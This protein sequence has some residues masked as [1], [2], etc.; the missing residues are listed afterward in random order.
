MTVTNRLPPVHPGEILREEMDERDL[1]ANALAE[2]LNIPTNRITAILNGQ[3][4]VTAETAH[5]LSLHFGTTS[6][7]WLN[8]QKTWELRCAEIEAEEG[9]RVKFIPSSGSLV[10]G[11]HKDKKERITEVL[12]DLHL[13]IGGFGTKSGQYERHDLPQTLGALAR[14]CSVFLRKLVLGDRGDRNTRLLDDAIMESLD[15]HLQPLRK[16]PQKQRRTIRTGFG[17]GNGFMV[18][19]KVDEPGP[20]LAP[21]YRLPIAPHDLEFSIEWPLPGTVDWIGIPSPKESW[22]ICAEQ[23]FDTGSARKLNC[24]NWL[25][26]QVVLFDSK[27]I[28]LK[29]IIRTVVTYEGVHAINVARLSEVD[30]QKSFRPAKEPDLHLLNNITLFGIRFPHLIVIETALYLYDR[31]LDEPSIQRPGGDIYLVK[32][33]FTCREDQAN[34]PRPD[35]LRFEG[36]IM[37]TFAAEPGL[38]RHTIRPVA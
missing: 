28:S 22:V 27:G 33:G 6:E 30:G 38:T 37:M 36:T 18:L 11:R 15:L 32:P 23:L 13:A 17:C 1:S 12:T 10:G 4:G 5:R 2:A 9:E 26:Q 3:R 29:D 19:T 8:L 35:W 20:G 34:S 16:I 14:L 7:F 31:L 24:D 25:S 21:T